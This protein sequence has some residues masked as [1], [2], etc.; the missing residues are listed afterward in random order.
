[1]SY[2]IDSRTSKFSIRANN[3]KIVDISPFRIIGM[4]PVEL[5]LRSL[6]IQIYFNE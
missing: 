5:T 2:V 6:K 4:I 1:M 3:L